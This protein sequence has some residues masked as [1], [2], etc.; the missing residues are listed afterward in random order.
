MRTEKNLAALLVVTALATAAACSTPKE[1][2]STPTST[3]TAEAGESS[4]V[5]FCSQFAEVYKMVG[6]EPARVSAGRVAEL[7]D[8]APSTLRP[9]V[10]AWSV[11]LER[12]SAAAGAEAGKKLSEISD[13]GAVDRIDKI[14]DEPSSREVV[15]DLFDWT[16]KNCPDL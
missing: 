10:E 3:T 11:V 16:S 7:A 6:N 15:Q 2:T 4:A 1:A 9:A 14:S 5:G 8:Q 12:V 13:P